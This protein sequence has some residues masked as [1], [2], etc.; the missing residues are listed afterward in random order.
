MST[1][2]ILVDLLGIAF[3]LAGFH[4]A[5]RQSLVRRWLDARRARQGL[6][7]I[8]PAAGGTGEDPL[9]SAMLIFGTM[10]MAF[11]IILFGFTTMYALAT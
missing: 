1:R 8:R 5:F 7:P 4:L 9:H 2:V 11:G 6:S 3:V 10:M